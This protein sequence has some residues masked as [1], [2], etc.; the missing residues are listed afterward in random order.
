MK[1]GA[2]VSS[3]Q[4]GERQG[5]LHDNMSFMLTLTAVKMILSFTC[6]LAFFDKFCYS[7]NKQLSRCSQL[8]NLLQLDLRVELAMQ[9]AAVFSRS[10]Q[11]YVKYASNFENDF[12]H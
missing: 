7:L 1:K 3:V 2:D 5:C 8:I 9:I 12:T 10:S 11:F 6:N 4:S